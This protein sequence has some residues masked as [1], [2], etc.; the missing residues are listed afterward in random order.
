MEYIRALVSTD[1]TVIPLR[2]ICTMKVGVSDD[3]QQTLSDVCG[4]VVVTIE[5]ING[6]IYICSM[7]E[8]SKM[9]TSSKYQYEMWEHDMD[10]FYSQVV[11]ESW[12][13]LG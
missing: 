10:G 12:L 4:D 5:T 7:L 2:N 1:N 6:K 13:L 9:Y 8:N 3:K 11:C